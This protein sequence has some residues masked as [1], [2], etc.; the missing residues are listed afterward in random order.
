MGQ[1]DHCFRCKKPLEPGAS[2]PTPGESDIAVKCPYCQADL[3][4]AP[5]RL[6]TC[7]TCGNRIH[8]VNKQ[9]LFPGALLTRDQADA[10]YLHS[11]L[12]TQGLNISKTAFRDTS[13]SMRLKLGM[14]PNPVE[15]V[16]YMAEIKFQKDGFRR[17]D[18][19]ETYE[20]YT[21][22]ANSLSAVGCQHAIVWMRRAFVYDLQQYKESGYA[23]VRIDCRE[24]CCR[25]CAEQKGQV[26]T[27]AEALSSMPL[28]N[29]RCS[30]ASE[31][32]FPCRCRYSV[33]IEPSYD[34][35][36]DVLRQ[37]LEEVD[38]QVLEETDGY[39]PVGF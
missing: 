13:H 33:Q 31:D 29:V 22:L 37:V 11:W 19:V 30:C 2:T 21:S 18:P 14:E 25:E 15:V 12:R 17:N 3:V 8:V 26:F 27:V 20:T 4:K 5:K 34:D 16:A 36:D 35:I 9:T 39:H 23:T 28:P 24:D 1:K 6:T 32:G 38:R 10:A 7:K